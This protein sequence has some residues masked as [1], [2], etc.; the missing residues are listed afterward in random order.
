MESVSG[1]A[2]TLRKL[3]IRWDVEQI[4]SFAPVS[5]WRVPKKA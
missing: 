5:G 3:L 2:E 4:L 1:A